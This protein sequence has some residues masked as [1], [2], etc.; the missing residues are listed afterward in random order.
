MKAIQYMGIIFVAFGILA[1]IWAFIRFI[2][3]TL[4]GKK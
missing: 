2:L 3:D 4:K 1:I